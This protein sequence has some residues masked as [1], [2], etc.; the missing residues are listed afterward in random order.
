MDG[1][2]ANKNEGWVVG[3]KGVILH[4]VNAGRTWKIHLTGADEWIMHV[5]YAGG[6]V[7]A[8]AADRLY[9]STDSGATW[10]SQS[11]SGPAPRWIWT[12]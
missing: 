6:V 12:S 2:F 1:V 4:T 11:I 10:K 9:T 5:D 3:S 8:V 7:R